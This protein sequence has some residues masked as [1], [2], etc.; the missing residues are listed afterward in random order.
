MVGEVKDMKKQKEYLEEQRDN[1]EGEIQNKVQ[2]KERLEDNIS[3]LE[4]Y[5]AALDIKESRFT[6]KP[7][8][9]LEL[10]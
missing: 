6:K 5:A 1:L 7:C 9:M 8:K 2:H 4:E 10:S 3:Q